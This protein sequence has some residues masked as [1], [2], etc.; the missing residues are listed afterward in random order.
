MLTASAR[1][2]VHSLPSEMT[3]AGTMGLKLL[4]ASAAN[5]S[6]VALVVW[7]ERK[8]DKESGSQTNR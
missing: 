6:M 4:P 8:R 3:I 1:L 5:H 2:W 7:H